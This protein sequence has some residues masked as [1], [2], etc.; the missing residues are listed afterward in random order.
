[1]EKSKLLKFIGTISMIIFII[2]F[3][4]NL[5]LHGG[6]SII[7]I[8]TWLFGCVAIIWVF[9]TTKFKNSKN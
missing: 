1:M 5:W 9:W 3:M 2:L 8:S 6:N 7:K 4:V